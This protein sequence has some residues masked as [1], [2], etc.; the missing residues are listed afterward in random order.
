[1]SAKKPVPVLTP[2]E[3]RT[4]EI[5]QI[6]QGLFDKTERRTLLRFVTDFEKLS[7]TP[8]KARL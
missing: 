2:L 4:A 7:A 3:K 8:P 5:R 1:M 6:A